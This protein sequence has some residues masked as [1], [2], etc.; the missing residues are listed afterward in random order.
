MGWRDDGSAVKSTVH[1]SRGLRVISHMQLTMPPTPLQG[2][3]GLNENSSCMFIGSGP[4]RR[5]GLFGLGIALLSDVCHCGW[6]LRLQ[7]LNPDQPSVSL[8]TAC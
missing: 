3:G 2:Y 6:A 4:T 1:S 5:H 8:L 7:K